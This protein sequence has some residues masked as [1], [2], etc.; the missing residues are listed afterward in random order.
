[1]V[2]VLRRRLPLFSYSQG[3]NMHKN[4]GRGR[5]ANSSCFL[6]EWLK[7]QHDI[8]TQE[9]GILAGDKGHLIQEPV[10]KEV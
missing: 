1:M 5:E 4:L 7:I 6:L 2:R 9:N 10:I 8:W 3:D